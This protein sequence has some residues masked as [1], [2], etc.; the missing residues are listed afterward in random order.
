[1]RKTIVLAVALTLIAGICACADLTLIG[2]SS[3]ELLNR[4][5]QPQTPPDAEQ[6]QEEELAGL[7]LPEM[8]AIQNDLPWAKMWLTEG[9]W[10]TDLFEQDPRGG[11]SPVFST[12]RLEELGQTIMLDWEER[13]AEIIDDAAL[14]AWEAGME[15]RE[16]QEQANFD[17][18]RAEMLRQLPPEVLEQMPP[19]VQEQIRQMIAGEVADEDFAGTAGPALPVTV[20]IEGPLGAET[21]LGLAC[22]QYRITTEVRDAEE[23]GPW[24]HLREEALVS[25]TGAIVPPLTTNSPWEWR[26]AMIIAGM[27]DEWARAAEGLTIP[28]GFAMKVHTLFEDHVAGTAGLLKGEIVEY[29]EDAIAPGVFEIPAGFTQQQ[30]ELPEIGAEEP[31]QGAP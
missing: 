24:G 15:E 5:D 19:E 14:G 27:P 25:L 20:T 16:A 7:S 17:Q 3:Y 4:P 22:T 2:T 11:A 6:L 18:N 21:V 12:I 31:A 1:M 29:S 30:F 26:G 8:L 28:D 9:K 13:T 23:D 10:R